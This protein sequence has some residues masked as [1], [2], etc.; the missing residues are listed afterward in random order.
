MT[1]QD[2]LLA[3][4]DHEDTF[5]WTH[6]QR[7]LIA[8]LIE[9]FDP[10]A[11][12]IAA[13]IG[14]GVGG[15]LAI[16]ETLGYPK[17]IALDLS[18]TALAVARR[19]HDR[20]FAVKA[21]IG[22]GLPVALD[23]VDT[24]AMLGVTCH[25]AI[26]DPSAAYAN[27]ASILAPGGLFI[28]TDPAFS[29]LSRAKDRRVFAARRFSVGDVERFGRSVGLEPLYVGY[30]TFF[31][32]LPALVLAA[33]DRI[34]GV[35]G[36]SAM[37]LETAMPWRWLNALLYRISAIEAKAIRAGI[38]FPVGVEVIGVFRKPIAGA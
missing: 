4:A 5:W 28:V 32:F 3:F 37:G 7:D 35:V 12:R 27:A 30:F 25:Q 20:A 17:L 31:A 23:S 8:A 1:A 15:N 26:A 24:V 6:A 33:F 13:D 21:D 2:D 16:F 34:F 11:K 22:K 36:G 9:K 10:R 19:R 14:C 38:R 18:E 29:I